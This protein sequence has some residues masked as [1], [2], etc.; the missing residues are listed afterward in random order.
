[1]LRGIEKNADP[2]AGGIVFAG[3]PES[4]ALTPQWAPTTVP[5]NVSVHKY[6]FAYDARRTVLLTISARESHPG[7]IGPS[8]RRLGRGKVLGANQDR[9]P[10]LPWLSSEDRRPYG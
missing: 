2:W 5:K 7:A 4:R 1:M 9:A 8:R 10:A 6:T 3:E